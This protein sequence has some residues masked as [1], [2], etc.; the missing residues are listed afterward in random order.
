MKFLFPS[1][2][3]FILLDDK[4]NSVGNIIISSKIQK[5][6]NWYR[7]NKA[8]AFK[9]IPNVIPKRQLLKNVIKYENIKP[10]GIYLKNQIINKYH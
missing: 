5:P 6:I 8:L 7:P 4:Y 1:K 3:K 9:H 10:R 2:F